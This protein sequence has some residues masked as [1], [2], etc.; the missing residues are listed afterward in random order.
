MTSINR[1]ICT[2]ASVNYT[3]QVLALAESV[4]IFEPE[5]KF[6]FLIV[7][8]KI[9]HYIEKLPVWISLTW[10]EDLA[11]DGFEKLA[12]V[13]DA[14]ELNTNVKPTFI[15]KL[16]ES[17]DQVV[18]LDPDI[19]LFAALDPVWNAL[20]NNSIVL[21]PHALTPYPDID[22]QPSEKGLLT[23]GVF[24]LGFIAFRR[25]S[26]ATDILEWWEKKCLIMGWNSPHDG[27]FVDQKWANLFPCYSTA[28]HILR[29]PGCNVAYWNL[30]ERNI[31]ADRTT[32]FSV[33]FDKKLY[34][35]VFFHFSG[36]NPETPLL[37]SKYQTRF[38]RPLDE[39]ESILSDYAKILARNHYG[40]WSKHSYGFS[41]TA[42]NSKLHRVARRAA[43]AF[44]KEASLQNMQ[45]STWL[46]K[47]RLATRG[48]NLAMNG[49]TPPDESIIKK[50]ILWWMLRTLLKVI[51]PTRY[52]AFTDYL[53]KLTS[54]D[55]QRK[56]FPWK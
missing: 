29:H 31:I 51:G 55:E 2:I 44:G 1:C 4:R 8:R 13:Y 7:D 21:T 18:Y 22:L 15:T 40:E 50:R 54:P 46:I 12:V 6:H 9:D 36:F 19:T 30:H 10:I 14:L 42:D 28:V 56:I 17:F 39:L 5:V 47:Q 32:E 11:I 53:P 24:N 43:I 33:E 41:R 16:L 35:L 38:Q 34:P 25:S 20:K 26:E 27:I 52:Q 23:V 45:L 49:N 3:G 48:E 37:L